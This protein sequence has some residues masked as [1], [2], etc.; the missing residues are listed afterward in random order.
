MAWVLL[1]TAGHDKKE[2]PF[3]VA[4]GYR[5]IWQEMR[6]DAVTGEKWPPPRQGLFAA[7]L[8]GGHGGQ[9]LAFQQLQGSAA[10][11]GDV[12]F[13]RYCCFCVS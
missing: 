10:A 4:L 9:Q 1:Q 5:G 3:R 11:G 7:I 13:S 6:A 12:P 8:Q 2:P